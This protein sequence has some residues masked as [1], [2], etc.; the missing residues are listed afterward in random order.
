MNNSVDKI[1]NQT[2][3]RRV[4]DMILD[5]I[6]QGKLKVDE[7]IQS[8]ALAQLFG[9]SRTPV[10]EALK[11]LEKTGLVRFQSYSGVYVRK[12]TEREIRE[13]YSIR[14]I[15]ETSAIE[16]AVEIV[17]S[18]DILLLEGLQQ[19][20]EAICNVS[21]LNIKDLYDANEKF[22]MA[23]YRISEMSRLCEIIETL[24]T[25][26]S[27]YRF[28]SASKENYSQEMMYEHHEYIRLFKKRDSAELVER[29]QQ[30][31]KLHSENIPALLEKYYSSL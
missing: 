9:V 7:K 27:F 10:R 11:S 2:L 13:I 22:H 26:L 24:W 28:L 15:L 14:L 6:I 29:I 17:T 1:D 31:L 4:Y 12:L 5:L 19:D 3:S 16:R 21:P 25:N 20:I 23:M 8:E 18:E 30:N